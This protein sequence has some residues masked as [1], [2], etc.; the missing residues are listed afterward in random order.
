MHP[1]LNRILRG[2]PRAVARALT[3]IDNNAP[4]K[5]ALLESLYTYSGKVQVVGF[6]GS[7]GAGKSTLVDKMIDFVRK[8]G[9]RVGVLAVD[10]SSPFSGGALLGDRVRMTKHSTDPGVYIR[11]VGSRGGLGGIGKSTREMLY[12]LEASG[13]DVIFLETV[14]VGQAELDVM[15]VAD[16][17]VLVLTPGAGDDVQTAK[18]GIMEIAHL[19]LVNKR[20]L[21]GSDTLIQELRL[22]LHEKTLLRENWLPPIVSAKAVAGEGMEELWQALTRH[23]EHLHESGFWE[24]RRRN[25]H[26]DETLKLVDAALSE[27]VRKRAK[28]DTEW[29]RILEEDLSQDPY[30]SAENILTNF[31]WKQL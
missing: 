4:D 23:Y 7:P 18:A 21:P 22:M 14:G 16:S 9:L 19:F 25:R 31:P 30:Q 13:C 3:L 11:S 6:T 15:Q 27:Y 29:K 1:L 28:E 17:V 26:R 8:Q 5:R 12:V 10:P 24:Q 2:E 20:D